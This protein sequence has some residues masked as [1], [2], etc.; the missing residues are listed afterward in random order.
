MSREKLKSIIDDFSIRGFVSF[1]REKS[2]SFAKSDDDLSQYDDDRFSDFYELGEIK[3]DDSVDRLVII[4]AKVNNELTDRSGKKAQYEK[5][6]TILKDLKRY[7]AAGIFIFYND[8][9][10]FRFSL[11]YD[12]SIGTKIIFNNFRRFTYFVSPEFTNRTFLQQIGDGEFS[13]LDN[14]K[15]SFS[16]EKVTK[17]FYKD[18][19]NWYFWAVHNTRFPEGA[20]K[21]ENGRNIAIIRLITRLIFI[22]FMRERGLVPKNLFDEDK[23]NEILKDLSSHSSTYYK[24][25][26]QNLF[27]A[28][29]NT[30]K[31]ERQFRSEQRYNKGYNPDFGNHSVYRYH[32]CFRDS[33][34]LSEYFGEIPFLNGGLF[35][36]LDDK[37][38]D[39]IIDGFSDTKKNQ[40]EVPNFL[41]FSEEQNVDLNADYGTTNKK[42]EVRGFLKILS[43]YNFTIDENDL[44]DQDVALDPELLGKVF[45]NLLAS[46]NPETAT[47]ARKATGSYYTPREIVDYMVTQ[48]LKAYFITHLADI[49]GVDQRLDKLLSSENPENPFDF[50]QSQRIVQLIE[51]VRIVDPA[52]GSG[53]FIMGALNKLVFILSKVDPKND[54]WKHEQ[55][56]VVEKIPDPRVKKESRDHIEK[57]FKEKNV[58]YGRKLYLI[59]KCIYGVDIQQIAVE[60]AKLRFFISLLVDEKIDKNHP[61]NNWG[62]QPLPNLDFK[63]MQGNSLISEFMGIDLDKEE[64]NR[65]ELISDNIDNLIEEFEQKKTEFQNEPDKDKKDNLKK[66]IDDLI[67]K[68]L[69]TKLEKQKKDYFSKLRAIEKKY[70]TYPNQSKREEIIA[71]EIEA[72][73]KRE[74][75]DLKKFEKELRKFTGKN[76]I[77]PF[78]AWKLYFAEVFNKESPGFDVVIGNPPYVS[79][80]AIQEGD[81][82]LLSKA[83]ETGEGRFNLFT[84]FIE[85]GF[86]SLNQ[87]G[88][89]VFIIPEGIFSNIEYRHTRKLLFENTV[90]NKICLFSERVFDAAV[91]TCV[92]NF[93]NS[94]KKES[95]IRIDRDLVFTN[96]TINQSNIG[97]YPFHIIPAKL[98]AISS[99]LI[100]KTI[101]NLK[102]LKL[103]DCLEIQQGIIYSG[104]AKED[105]FSNEIINKTYKKCL[106]GRDVLRWKIN[107]DSKEENKFIS[108]TNKLHR[109]REERLYLAKE[110]ILIPR[111]AISIYGTIDKHQFY[112]LN[113]AY[114]CL[115]KLPVKLSIEYLMSILN[116]NFINFIYN[117]LFFGWQITIPALEILPVKEID[118]IQ[119]K[120]FIEI[121]D[122]ILSITESND[123]LT[124]P[125]KQA[126]VKE[127]EHQID[128]MVYELYGLTPEEIAIVEGKK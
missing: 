84:L 66:D 105:V 4:G 67:I 70:S 30:K 31:E 65:D 88:N 124:N 69:E 125:A 72:L 3:F 42:Y 45:E 6:K 20:E 100:E 94:K 44:N 128:E 81:K 39:L 109:P 12:Q 26:L 101:F 8:S 52:V 7:N 59:Q 32:D 90:I 75:F 24:A 13:S 10:K 77:K 54:F 68:I 95:F 108:Y 22:W 71:E 74:G 93:S 61:D 19:A 11:I 92:I 51:N 47:T 53:A 91:D 43:S 37:K 56:R 64:S 28:T 119:Q 35:E 23:V 85:K 76:S 102:Y 21:E 80:K 62:I 18:I 79:V 127:Y 123:Y 86:R 78:F 33:Q 118:K 120:P 73:S 48:S 58:D 89:L 116:S 97:R 27:F 82:K 1:F 55:L 63:I 17:E 106:D 40:P 98:N 113:T 5:A 34:K 96:Y 117:R 115:N 46:F 29:L 104:Q 126:K 49:D 99:K 9:G 14:I 36:C 60:I 41:F 103:T 38:N 114:I 83:F 122:K 15:D 87:M 2:T 121:V 110:K 16:V 25:I 50:S 112:V 107:W 57:L 111:R